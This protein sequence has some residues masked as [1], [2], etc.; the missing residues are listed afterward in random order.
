MNN[1]ISQE[2]AHLAAYYARGGAVEAP[3][4]VDVSRAVA[5]GE[6][7]Y[8]EGVAVLLDDWEDKNP[9]P[10]PEEWKQAADLLM[11]WRDPVG[12]APGHWEW[13]GPD[14]LEEWDVRR[15]E[16]ELRLTA[17]MDILID[18]IDSGMDD[19]PLAVV[20][21]DIDARAMIGL[22]IEPDG[23]LSR[24]EVN[25][26]L[27]G[28][29]A[30]GEVI[31]GKHYAVEKRIK[32]DPKTQERRW[33]TPIGSY[34]FCPT[35][36]KTVSVGWGFGDEAEQA[37]ILHAH[38]VSARAAMA[39]IAD[40]VGKVRLGNGGEDGTEEGTVAWL[41][42]THH[43]SRRVQV[44]TAG[45]DGATIVSD[46]G[47]S[48]D[49]DLHTHFLIPNAVFSLE[50]DKVGSLDTMAIRGFIKEA[51]Q[52]Y[53]AMLGQALR[54]AGFDVAMD[55]KTGAAR[56]TAVPDD[57]RTLFSKRTNMGEAL[58]KAFTVQRGEVWEQL[59]DDQRSARVKHATQSIEQKSKGQK[60]D[61]ADFADWRQQAKDVCGWEP[62]SLLRYGPPE[63]QLTG[64]E[65]SRVAY[66]VGLLP[67]VADKLEHQAV[68]T[69][70]D[71]RIG[72]L[73]G[74]VH[75]GID[76][77]K[78]VDAITK[79]AWKEGVDQYGERTAIQFGQEDGKRYV[80]VTTALHESQETE[81]IGLVRRAAADRSGAI[82]ATVLR[83]NLNNANLDWTDD[84]GMAMREA[85]GRA[86]TGGKFSLIIAAAGAGKTVALGPM[87]ASWKEQGRDVWVSS[88]AW[89]QADDMMK[90]G[91]DRY[92]TRAFSVLLDGLREAKNSPGSNWAVKLTDRSVVVVDEWGLIGTRQSLELMRFQSEIGFTVVALGDPKQCASV[93]AGAVID[94]SKRAL[95]PENVP[96]I[97]TTKRQKS[98]REKEIVGLFRDGEA[99][100]ALDMKRQDGQADMAYGGREGTIAHTAKVY[101]HYLTT[102][103]K[104]PAI[105]TPT[106]LDAHAISAAVRLERRKLGQLGPDVR[107]IKATDGT[108]VYDLP[109]AAG[110][111]VR[112]FHSTGANFG[113][114]KG[115]LIGR[116]GSVLD[117]VGADDAGLTLRA[118]TGKVGVVAWAS[119]QPKGGGAVHLA[120]GDAM[121]VHTSQGSSKGV[122]ISSLPGGSESLNT[123]MGY[124]MLTRHYLTSH[125]IT[126]EMKERTLVRES[127][128][129]N[130]QHE[131][132][133]DDKW[134]Q[135]AK[136]LA[137]QP[138]RDSA[139]ALRARVGAM[140]RGTVAGFQRIMAPSGRVPTQGPS[141]VQ[142][143]GLAARVSPH[144]ARMATA[145]SGH[146]Q[147]VSRA[148][149]QGVGWRI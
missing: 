3:L 120:Y 42:F 93:E 26:L 144:I 39:Y 107:T 74:L 89:R 147:E 10:T 137:Y 25:A 60:D 48:G 105:N 61:K 84:H 69:H 4:I 17:R 12:K 47:F 136:A 37:A 38:T 72:A 27:A 110:D 34:D 24:D 117:V 28:L 124:S 46:A 82:P 32:V 126:N 90:T 81:F 146:L 15:L 55:P 30:D 130:S 40:T 76:S 78:D 86:G 16:A 13:T 80:S 145:L 70:W 52:Y 66:E 149:T 91:V 143:H 31:E 94:L 5:D 22:G 132:T 54:D 95:G 98:D 18:R 73:R 67:H 62:G 133:M 112:L 134:S 45:P 29:R 33:S 6:L 2:H 99:A 114:G 63:R 85:I 127:R 119:L 109:L 142:S 19:A 51:D 75:T 87:V 88:L 122:Q 71:L 148:A 96:V 121:T 7:G 106:N 43:T 65:R 59:T 21:P 128:P 125:L 111:R 103:G 92:H 9:R 8:G 102:T 118:S 64:A 116:N 23:I 36:D 141:V 97:T 11:V 20:R 44:A 108:T 68:L 50:S 113:G 135:V 101:T 58:A 100:E 79:I 56:L 35:P 83:R 1:T 14:P 140:R 138:E 123:G 115:G 49:P 77:L 131:I 129:L 53:H 104:A 57:A 139:T 41:E